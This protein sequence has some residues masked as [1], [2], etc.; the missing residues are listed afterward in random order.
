MTLFEVL[1]WFAVL[2]ASAAFAV[3]CLVLLVVD[4]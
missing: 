1:F 2:P 4:R 3:A